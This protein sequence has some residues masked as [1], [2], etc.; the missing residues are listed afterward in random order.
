M[1]PTSSSQANSVRSSFETRSM[2]V[3]VACDRMA[4][5]I[6]SCSYVKPSRKVEDVEVAGVKKKLKDKAFARGV[7]RDDIILGVTEMAVDLDAHIGFC[8]KAMQANAT[9]LGL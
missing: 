4:R 7:N 5:R 6:S 1:K 3:K 9:A 2:P 8:L